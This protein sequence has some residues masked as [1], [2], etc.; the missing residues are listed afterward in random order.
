MRDADLTHGAFYSHFSDKNDLRVHHLRMLSSIA[1]IGFL[2]QRR[3]R[4]GRVGSGVS[5]DAI[6]PAATG[7]IQPKAAC[8]RH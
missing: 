8:L 5:L 7:I 3:M 1:Q 6:F 4:A 2:A